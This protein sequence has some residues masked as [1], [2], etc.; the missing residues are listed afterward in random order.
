M[1]KHERLETNSGLLLL[2]VLVIISIGGLIEVVPLFYIDGT[3][4]EVKK[5]IPA[6]E[7]D[8]DGKFVLDENGKKV[9]IYMTDENGEFILDERNRK[10]QATRKVDAI[11]PY[12]PLELL[13][14]NIYV[15]E[16]C[17][18][19][20]SQQ[21]RPMQD[22]FERYGHYS[23]AAESQYDKP[24]QWGSRRIGPD[25]ARVG[26]KMDNQWHVDHLF[27]PQDRVEQSIMPAYPWLVETPLDYGS[28]EQHLKT[29]RR[30]GVPYSLTEEE[31]QANVERF[32]EDV[33]IQLD[34]GLAK[35]HLE[36]DA[37]EI[38]KTYEHDS[39]QPGVI[40]K[41]DAL[42]AYLQVLGTM[43]EFKDDQGFEFS[44]FR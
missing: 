28:V 27:K 2:F 30:L 8:A 18:T 22:E 40:T 1:I 9:P 43:V 33:A 41:V 15:A 11:R 29:L 39:K 12:T 32:G 20:H 23:L 7:T 19:C 21:I 44:E 17:Y 14:R 37:A 3:I 13:G 35:K 34:I 10:I 16:G 42:I 26:G 24:F 38:R 31:Y 25:L 4:E 5:E 36:A 6:Y